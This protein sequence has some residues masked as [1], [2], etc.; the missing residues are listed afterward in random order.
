MCYQIRPWQ[1]GLQPVKVPLYFMDETY[2]N[3]RSLNVSETCNINISQMC[4]QE[5][6]FGQTDKADFLGLYC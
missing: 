6:A 3:E 2:A 1:L 4:I 5:E